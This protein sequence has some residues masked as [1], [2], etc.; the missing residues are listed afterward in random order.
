ML[1]NRINTTH[2]HTCSLK[3]LS[4]R[5][6]RSHGLQTRIISR[7]ERLRLLLGAL[8]VI[9][10]T[11]RFLGYDYLGRCEFLKSGSLITGLTKFLSVL[12]MEFANHALLIGIYSLPR[13]SRCSFGLGNPGPQTGKVRCQTILPS[14]PSCQPDNNPDSRRCTIQATHRTILSQNCLLQL[15]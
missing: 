15:A 9:S 11:K 8:R 2:F 7:R 12:S 13:P 1:Q 4:A 5:G 3:F 10:H 6:Y 14:C